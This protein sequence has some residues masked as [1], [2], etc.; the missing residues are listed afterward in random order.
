MMYS[1]LLGP[2]GISDSNMTYLKELSMSENNMNVPHF[3]NKNLSGFVFLY[4]QDSVFRLEPHVENGR[5]KSPYDPK[6]LT[7]SMLIGE[8]ETGYTVLSFRSLD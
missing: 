6:L 1:F 5:G 8:F 7:A 2:S 4:V 3:F